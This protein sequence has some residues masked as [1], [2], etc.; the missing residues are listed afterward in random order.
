VLPVCTPLRNVE[1]SLGFIAVWKDGA[2]GH[3]EYVAQMK[4]LIRERSAGRNDW[5]LGIVL[6]TGRDPAFAGTGNQTYTIYSYIPLS[7]SLANERIVLHQNTGWL[8]ARSGGAGENALTW[9]AR[10]DV[11]LWPRVALI[12]EAYG[13]E[14]VDG[15]G[16][17]PAELQLGLKTW[18]RP[19]RVTLDVGYGGAWRR[20]S[21]RKAGWTLGLTLITPPFL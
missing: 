7:I 8:Y 18:L 5:S 12:G 11:S 3:F 16:S 1:L 21:Q 17:I 19:D 6:G 2:D 14:M 15:N 10:A 20:P 9:A 4:S 13:A